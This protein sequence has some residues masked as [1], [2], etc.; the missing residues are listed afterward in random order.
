MSIQFAILGPTELR[1]DDQVIPLGT[2]KV[3]A[4]LAVL[5]YHAGEHV[6]AETIMELLWP[7]RGS[8]TA[9]R[10]LYAPVSR[11]RAV[12]R[13]AGLPHALVRGVNTGT[14]RLDVDRNTVDYYRFRLLVAEARQA[15]SQQQLERAVTALTTAI[16]LWR[17]EPL[18]ELRGAQAEHLRRDLQTR[19]LDAQ[20]LLAGGELALGRH[21]NAFTRLEQ[22]IPAHPLDER[23]AS[24]WA[25]ALHAVG[26]SPDARQFVTAFRHH[27]RRR[28]RTEPVL[29]I[30]PAPPTPPTP[31]REP[32]PVLLPPAAAPSRQLPHDV[33]DF[34]GR[35]DLISTLDIAVAGGTNIIVVTGMPGVGKTTLAVHWAH[36]KR[37]SF[38]D[39]QLY[40]NAEAH[41]PVP[42]LQPEDALTR[43]LVALGVPAKRVPANLEEQRSLYQ[44]LTIER[45][46]LIIL[47]NILDSRQAR[48]LIPASLTCLTIITSRTRLI[49]LNIREAVHTITVPP[50]TEPQRHQ[51]LHR[52]LASQRED[53]PSESLTKIARLSGGIP[54]AL[55]IIGEQIA[56]RP[57][58]PIHELADDLAAHLLDY[59]GDETGETTLRTIF[60]WSTNHLPA[61]AALVFARLGLFPGPTIS[62]PAA[63]ALAGIDIREAEADL[64]TLTRT[65]LVEHDVG[66]R[67]RMHDL[68]RLYAA[69]LVKTKE[70]P[71]RRHHALRRLL[72]WY[73]LS[74]A[75]AARLIDPTNAPVPDLPRP[76]QTA[77]TLTTLTG[78]IE[79]IRWCEIERV[80]LAPL[81]Q[82]AK[83]E[84]YY[85]HAWQIPGA[86]HGA[87]GR[88]GS[89]TDV[90]QSLQVAVD[91]ARIDGH[92]E[93]LLGSLNNLGTTQL[94][95]HDYQ[96]AHDAFS[97]A[98]QLAEQ[99]NHVPAQL[100]CGHN[101]AVARMRSGE[102]TA[103]I[104]IL[105]QV[106]ALS[107]TN[108]IPLGEGSALHN[109]GDAYRAL[110]QHTQAEW[111]YHAA[112]AIWDKIDA[113]RWRSRDI[114]RLAKL[115]LE[116]GSPQQALERCRLALDLYGP[117]IDD[118]TRCDAHITAADAQRQLRHYEDALMDAVAAREVAAG[119]HD[120]LRVAHAQAVTADTL[121]A[122]GDTENAEKQIRVALHELPDGSSAAIQSLRARLLAARAEL[123]HGQ[124]RRLAG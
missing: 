47:D 99:I 85:R 119:R 29:D 48:Q 111:F 81:V 114:V 76:E 89:Q 51:L 22:L 42:P 123:L 35:D 8:E 54:L 80:N 101:V 90:L 45:R 46:L 70:T 107:R 87:F 92:D 13:T 96:R 82:L 17:G 98:L 108:E 97:Q 18:P 109:L 95:A 71:E 57:L 7:Q 88:Y 4:L 112:I 52:I 14:Y 39:G 16:N 122:M 28:M 66:G 11:V 56:V 105:E 59:E 79:A 113:P 77:I 72:D 110:K 73:L 44:Q 53:I 9:R 6:R 37:Q 106:L 116:T 93:G 40:L 49:G 26:R 102:V 31:T 15:T 115:D 104:P 86:T 64:R 58:A 20:K 63:A 103:A 120:R 83:A 78:Q 21:D 38:P 19:Q 124:S 24:L 50:L 94:D 75:N 34:T 5:L 27:Y 117:T 41:G 43:L 1:V 36:R 74:A 118:S 61:R 23:L 2:A 10:L 25:T 65:H 3:R 67:F 91:A 55:R 68:L 100:L 121:V 33:R 12:L 30:R 84:G 69:D 32:P 62:T 60:A